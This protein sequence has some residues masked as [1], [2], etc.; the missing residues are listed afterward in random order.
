MEPLTLETRVDVDGDTY[1]PFSEFR[2]AG[3]L[4]LANTAAFNPRG[5]TI[6]FHYGTHDFVEAVGWSM[7]GDGR[8]P[9]ETPVFEETVEMMRRS[10][11]VMP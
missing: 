11:A 6:R 3:L 9:F 8:V 2:R 5:Y 4:W 7:A 10:K 1:H